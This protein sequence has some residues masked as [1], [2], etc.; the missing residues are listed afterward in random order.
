MLFILNLGISDE[1]IS[2]KQAFTAVL[3]DDTSCGDNKICRDGKCILNSSRNDLIKNVY[4][5]SRSWLS[6]LMSLDRKKRQSG[7]NNTESNSQ[8]NSASITVIQPTAATAATTTC[9]PT[10]AKGRKRRNAILL[11]TM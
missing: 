7:N 1:L 11:R 2:E 4:D 6:H 9:P 3:E 5:D 8:S 10:A